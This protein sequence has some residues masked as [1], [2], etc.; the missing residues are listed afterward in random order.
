VLSFFNVRKIVRA[1]PVD[2]QWQDPTSE[3]AKNQGDPVEEFEKLVAK[4]SRPNWKVQVLK[5]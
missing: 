5:I 4:R 1:M 2:W 3:W